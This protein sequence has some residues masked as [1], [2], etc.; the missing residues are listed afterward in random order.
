MPRTK[1]WTPREHRL[2][3]RAWKEVPGIAGEGERAL[4]TRIHER[5]AELC[6]GETERS[7]NAVYGQR[8]AMLYNYR[9]IVTY[10]KGR[11]PDDIAWFDLSP[12]GREEVF[13]TS[14]IDQK[15]IS[16]DSSMYSTIKQILAQPPILP[17]KAAKRTKDAP[18]SVAPRSLTLEWTHGELLSLVRAW[19]DETMGTHKHVSGKFKPNNNRRIHE[20]FAIAC[21]GNTTRSPAAVTTKRQDLACSYEFINKFNARQRQNKSVT[22]FAMSKIEKL[23]VLRGVQRPGH[24]YDI[25]E[26]VFALVGQVVDG[27]RDSASNSSSES[28]EEDTVDGTEAKPSKTSDPRKKQKLDAVREGTTTRCAG[29]KFVSKE[30][31]RKKFTAPRNA[32]TSHQQLLEMAEALSEQSRRLTKMVRGLQQ[33]TAAGAAERAKTARTGDERRVIFNNSQ[34][35]PRE[36]AMGKVKSLSDDPVTRLQNQGGGQGTSWRT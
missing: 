36:P 23:A 12:H 21:G 14:A 8:C 6:G 10:E 24:I 15:Y 17:Q 13:N 1:V 35:S 11:S 28:E 19:R 29:G 22:W 7:E 33:A 31:F 30:S 26:D 27:A 4:C 5:F 18:P 3:L 9:F 2:L 16:L 20:R 32:D 34:R 25:P